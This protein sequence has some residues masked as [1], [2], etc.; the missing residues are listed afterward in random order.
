[1]SVFD[2]REVDRELA[3]EYA[4]FAEFEAARLP[5]MPL[6][7][8]ERQVG[9]AAVLGAGTVG[10]GIAMAFVNAGV[11]VTLIEPDASGIERGLKRIRD[12]YQHEVR[13]GRLGAELVARRM[14]LVR[15]GVRLEDAGDA[16]L[17]I[18][19]GTADLASK[20]DR[21]R[22]LDGIAR[23]GAI[24]AAQASTGT[25]VNALASATS[26]PA[27]V[28]GVHFFVPAY[29]VRLL[30]VVRTERT[31]PDVS[32]TLMAVGA[33]M[34]KVAVLV[35]ASPGLIGSALFRRLDADAHRLVED[36]ALPHE[37]DDALGSLGYAMGVFVLHDLAGIDAGHAAFV[38][39]PAKGLDDR[40]HGDSGGDVDADRGLVP[41][42]L[43][44][45]RLGQKNGRGW[46]RYEAGS[47][48]PMRDTAFEQSLL[49]ECA[50][51]GVQRRAFAREEILERCLYGMVN[52]GARL[53]EQGIA[54]RPSDIDIVLLAGHGYPAAQGGPLFMADRIGLPTVAEAMQRLHVQLG[55]RW[56]PAPLLLKLARAGGSFAQWQAERPAAAH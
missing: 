6:G 12:H 28:I 55:P 33:R 2:L 34:G 10:G 50:R 1:M 48:T 30:E 19:A 53:L 21:F 40:R 51:R 25:E 46:Y 16:D 29:A 52:E 17:V 47:R 20:C 27:D 49:A 24:L 7:T 43:G 11:S 9:R 37:V 15:A 8:G 35:R 41:W 56:L 36:G 42:L 23:P 38:S 13:R 14:A 32:A 26:R 3:A 18:E 45:G 4:K 54:Q 31:A 44:L 5:D 22:R 39:A